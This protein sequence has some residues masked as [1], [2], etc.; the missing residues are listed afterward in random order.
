MRRYMSEIVEAVERAGIIHDLFES[1]T[2]PGDQ[3][4]LFCCLRVTNRLF[5]RLV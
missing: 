5:A 3:A 2:L 1:R 4:V